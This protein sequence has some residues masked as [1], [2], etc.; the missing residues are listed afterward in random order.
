MVNAFALMIA[1]VCGAYFKM[2]AAG[3]LF[4]KSQDG[5]CQIPQDSIGLHCFGDY[6][7]IRFQSI[8]DS[9]LPPGNVYPPSTRI[10]LLP[11]HYADK[12]YGFRLGLFLFLA[13]SAICLLFP[14]VVATREMSTRDRL[15]LAS[16]CGITTYPFLFTLDRGNPIALAVPGIFIFIRVILKHDRKNYYWAV[17]ALCSS[18]AIKPQFILFFALFF[19]LREYKLFFKSLIAG[20]LTILIPFLI[21]FSRSWLEFQNWLSAVS[22]WGQSLSMESN[23][24]ANYSLMHFFVFIGIPALVCTVLVIVSGLFFLLYRWNTKRTHLIDVMVLT[25]LIAFSNPINYGYYTILFIPVLAIYL[26]R[27][28]EDG[29]NSVLIK[30]GLVLTVSPLL[31]P[32]QWVTNSQLLDNK[33]FNLAPLFV[34]GTWILF[35]IVQIPILIVNSTSRGS[36][37]DSREI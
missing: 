37:K 20:L 22:D 13:I 36:S 16:L 11:F 26:V 10:F 17:L 24:P 30:I 29:F 7:A 32:S 19:L 1:Y 27:P 15:F 14:I 23:Y 2:D 25:V 21:Y 12:L 28:V 8:F 34:V 5:H 3:L 31:I 9:P 6:S 18:V 4:Y 33:T 35:I